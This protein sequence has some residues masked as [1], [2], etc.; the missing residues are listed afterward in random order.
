VPISAIACAV[1]SGLILTSLL[2]WIIGIAGG[3]GVFQYMKGRAQK[4]SASKGLTFSFVASAD[5]LRTGGGSVIQRSDIAELNWTNWSL[6][7]SQED[8]AAIYCET[9]DGGSPIL[10]NGMDSATASRLTAEVAK[11]LNVSFREHKPEL[12]PST[13]G[14]SNM[15]NRQDAAR[16]RME[17]ARKTSGTSDALAI[18]AGDVILKEVAPNAFKVYT[19]KDTGREFLIDLPGDDLDVL[20]MFVDHQVGDNGGLWFEHIGSDGLAVR[21]PKEA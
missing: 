19:Q 8:Q 5:S 15:T 16:Q 18:P 14:M 4:S 6:D 21:L 12:K 10:A 9:R 11:V 7:G 13:P 1:V 3:W 20:W 2:H 17:Q